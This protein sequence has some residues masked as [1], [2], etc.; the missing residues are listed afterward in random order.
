M[1]HVTTIDLFITDL[2]A[3]SK[4]CERLGLELVIGQKTFKWFGEFVGDYK[5][6]DGIDVKDYGKCEHAIRVKGNTKAYEIG[7]VKRNDGKPGYRL[8]WDFFA[9]GFGLCEKVTY[10]K[11]AAHSP[12]ADKLKD[13][14]AAE[15]AQKQMRRQGFRVSAFQRD[16]K[17][18]VT[19]SK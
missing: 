11:K 16:K 18:E 17:V 12:N 4:A 8:A 15:V 2:D 10:D 19:C 13:W 1:S 3:L 6:A 14:Y 7:L 5:K 9:G